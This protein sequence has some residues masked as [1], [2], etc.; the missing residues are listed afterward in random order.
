MLINSEQKFFN[1]LQA[2]RLLTP[3]GESSPQIS[4]SDRVRLT[5]LIA[6]GWSPEDAVLFLRDSG[7]RSH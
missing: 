1:L 7:G 6:I 5:R 2:L 3:T 4:E